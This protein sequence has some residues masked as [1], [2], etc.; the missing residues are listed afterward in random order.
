MLRVGYEPSR[1]KQRS[2][3]ASTFNK[4][5]E[6]LPALTVAR[7]LLHIQ[8]VA[9]IV[10]SHDGPL[11]KMWQMVVCGKSAPSS[12]AGWFFINLF[13]FHPE[14]IFMSKAIF[15]FCIVGKYKKITIYHN[16]ATTWS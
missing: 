5:L 14:P 2:V 8:S 16:S 6:H 10:F 3:V 4:C 12:L 15:G 7:I 9:S 1:K 11:K 13:S